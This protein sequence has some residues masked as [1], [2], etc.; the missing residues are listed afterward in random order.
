L[1][2]RN[3]F[4]APTMFNALR[5]TRVRP[6]F[7]WPRRPG[8]IV[9]IAAACFAS[10]SGVTLAQAPAPPTSG[11][12]LKC[13]DAK[14]ATT[15][16]DQAQAARCSG[17]TATVITPHGL[18]IGTKPP[19]R[20]LQEVS[21]DEE[22]ARLAQVKRETDAAVQ[23]QDRELLKKYP[24]E[25]ALRAARESDLA[26]LRAS[27]ALAIKRLADLKVDRKP[28]DDEAEFYVGKQLP[29]A[30]KAA[31]RDNDARV[32]AQNDLI[33]HALDDEAVVVAKFKDLLDQMA[34]LWARG[35]TV[36]SGR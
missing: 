20:S 22:T 30:L 13:T 6:I 12:I 11:S 4:A 28:L 3:S 2:L 25:N 1:S 17:V 35:G 29:A 24:T 31:L 36:A 21:D 19:A 5:S 15:I 34:S 32:A 27:H 10:F 14:G 23:R 33:Q 16:V 8:L 7:L 9:S 18:P 26:P